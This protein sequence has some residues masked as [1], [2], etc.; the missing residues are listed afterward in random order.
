MKYCII[1]GFDAPNEDMICQV[2]NGHG[3]YLDRTKRERYPRMSIEDAADI[4]LFGFAVQESNG[5]VVFAKIN[6]SQAKYPDGQT[7]RWQGKSDFVIKAVDP[8]IDSILDEYVKTIN[9]IDDLFE[10]RYKGMKKEEI[11]EKVI[12]FLNSLTERIKVK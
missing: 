10:H 11:K 3:Y 2:I 4:E 12:G 6:E 9:Q 5:F 8:T 1:N 7:R